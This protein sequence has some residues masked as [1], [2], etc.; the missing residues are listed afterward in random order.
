MLTAELLQCVIHALA[1]I[2]KPGELLDTF[3]LSF[4]RRA[5]L[6]AKPIYRPPFDLPAA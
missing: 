1:Q 5:S 3:V 2:T 6:K 4:A